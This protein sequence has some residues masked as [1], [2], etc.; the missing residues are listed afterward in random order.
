MPKLRNAKTDLGAFTQYLARKC[1]IHS[2]QAELDLKGDTRQK[3]PRFGK[4]DLHK[5]AKVYM[6]RDAD[7]GSQFVAISPGGR[8]MLVTCEEVD[9]DTLDENDFKKV[10]T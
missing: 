10:G 7:D 3:A 1:C 9:P 2:P 8:A 5:G 6:M 4:S